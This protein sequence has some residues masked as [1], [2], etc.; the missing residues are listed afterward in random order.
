MV[1][2]IHCALPKQEVYGICD[3]FVKDEVIWLEIRH[4][5]EADVGMKPLPERRK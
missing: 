4:G 1:F 2:W 3:L 5:M